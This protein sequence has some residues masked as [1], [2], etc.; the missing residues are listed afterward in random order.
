MFG[1]GPMCWASE[2]GPCGCPVSLSRSA[3]R[4]ALHGF[5]PVASRYDWMATTAVVTIGP[6]P[7]VPPKEPV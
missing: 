4:W 7:D 1:S 6:P 5:W 3:I 2:F